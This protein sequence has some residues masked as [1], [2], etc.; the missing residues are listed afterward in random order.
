MNKQFKR[1]N[2]DNNEKYKALWEQVCIEK[3]NF[4]STLE[5]YRQEH[6]KEREEWRGVMSTQFQTIVKMSSENTKVLSE[7]AILLKNGNKH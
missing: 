6:R 5:M 1:I 3:K 4:V 7:L 2:D